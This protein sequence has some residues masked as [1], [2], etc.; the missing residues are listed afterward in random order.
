MA[1][2][3]FLKLDGIKGE[4][5]DAKHPSTVEILSFSWGVSNGG[6]Q[7]AGS[8]VSIN[9]F[10]FVHKLDKSTPSL[11]LA[12]ATG[13]HIPSAVLTTRKA[14]KTQQDY[15]KFTFSDIL[16]SSYQSGGHSSGVPTDQFSLNFAKVEISY[17]VTK[18]DGSLASPTKAILTNPDRQG[19]P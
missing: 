15:L 9:D 1:V 7:P 14:G 3:M 12:C 19:S 16:V 4:A 10:S 18:P 2:D 8:Q 5:N 13:Q 6:T 17:A 11:M